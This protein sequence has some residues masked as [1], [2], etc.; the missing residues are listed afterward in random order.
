MHRHHHHEPTVLDELRQ[1]LTKEFW[2]ERYAGSG[3]VWSG[4]PNQRLVEQTADLEPGLALDVG[5][6]EGADAIWLAEQGW[7]VTAV[8]VSTV[9]LDRTAQHA[10]ERGVDDRVRVGQY[11]VL[12]GHPPRRP[13]RGK[14]YDLVS[15]HFLHVPRED[16][17]GIYRRLGEVVAPGGRLLV[18]AHHPDDLVTGA[19]S[20]HGPNLLFPPE[21]VLA[22]FGVADGDSATWAVDV[23]DAPGREQE[24]PDGPVAVRDTV[25]R[26]RRR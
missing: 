19:R 5:C 26:L 13:R 17:D 23:A 21:Q 6:G 18:V 20:W 22:T 7:R 9:A 14:G 1:A 8:D 4:R 16:F 24:T 10:I 12:A 11:D 15:V 2:D 3:R 25:V